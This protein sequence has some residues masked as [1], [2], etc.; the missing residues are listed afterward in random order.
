MN[1]A[2]PISLRQKVLAFV[3]ALTILSL[4]TS[5]LTLFRITEVSRQLDAINRVSVPLGRLFVQIQSDS[6]LLRR[7]V[8]RSLGS[9]HWSDP[10][11]R[12]RSVP[13][14]I[15]EVLEGEAARLEELVKSDLEWAPKDA[16]AKWREWAASLRTSF[17]SL[18]GEASQL[19][20]VLETK[21]LEEA[22][23][24]HNRM[25]LGLE[26]WR[27]QVW[28]GAAEYEQLFRQGFADAERR[29][30]SLRSGLEGM[31]GVVVLLS[32]VLLWLGEKALR[33]MA[34]LTRLAHEIAERGLRKEDKGSLPEMPLSRRDEVSRLAREFHRM[35][36]T[37]LEREKTVEAQQKRL[38]DQNRELRKMGELQEKLR[39]A[40]NLAAIG[41]MSAQVAHEV[42]NPLHSIGLE[43]ELALELASKSSPALKQSL[44]SILSGVDR[45]EKITENYLKLSRPSTTDRQV[46]NLGEVLENVLATYA[47]ELEARAV[48]VDWTR[49]DGSDLRVL[50]NQQILEQALGNLL[51]NALQ[52]LEGVE[53]PRIEW[54]VGT[55]ESGR[56]YVRI[57]DNGP[58]IPDSL[59]E[60]LFTPFVTTKAQGTGLGLAFVKKAVEDHGGSVV[61]AQ[62]EAGSGALFELTIPILPP[63]PAPPATQTE[64]VT[65]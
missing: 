49:A 36:T 4:A 54:S 2:P 8:E 1:S 65:S 40:E 13:K 35:A 55:L 62:P 58:G 16:R 31:L 61:L 42:R 45:L 53:N 50:G 5:T 59:K 56:V 28:G 63:L 6:D 60:K 57:R 30:V 11:W 14:W 18:Q 26:A 19:Q 41:R 51:R 46:V 10:H 48:R 37:L 17:R 12:P 24:I 9:Q 27:R 33:P 7:E 34:D 47:H 29:M 3:G 38:M 32:L 39:H 23:R 21:N 20:S 15:T 64:E 22:Q 25:V 52:A 43:A 44:Q